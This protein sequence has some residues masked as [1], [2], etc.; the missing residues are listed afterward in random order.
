MRFKREV[1]RGRAE[2]P[3]LDCAVKARGRERVGIFWVESEVHDIVCMSFECLT[4]C[5]KNRARRTFD[6]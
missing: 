6:H 1:W 2:A 3:H 4:K 5:I